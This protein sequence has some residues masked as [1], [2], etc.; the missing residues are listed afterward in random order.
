MSF[1]IL[2]IGIGVQALAYRWSV[3][4]QNLHDEN[5]I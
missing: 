2:G 4:L 3:T 1:G 5:E